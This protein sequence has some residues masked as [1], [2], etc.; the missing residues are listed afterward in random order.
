MNETPNMSYIHQLSGGEKEFEKRLIEI[1]KREFPLEKETYENNF[2]NSEYELC[3]EN[4][5]KLKHKISILGLEQSYAFAI[6]YEDDL[7][8][9]STRLSTEFDEILEVMN[10]FIIKL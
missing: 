7:K 9:G 1:L 6:K 3:A 2:Q 5:H 10:Q 4:V 8:T